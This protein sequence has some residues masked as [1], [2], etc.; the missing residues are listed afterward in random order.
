MQNNILDF[1]EQ[2]F[3][4]KLKEIYLTENQNLTKSRLE[5]T[6]ITG[7]THS[8]SETEREGEWYYDK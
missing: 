8:I 2:V 6:S 7:N 4:Q 1:P 3:K 5:R